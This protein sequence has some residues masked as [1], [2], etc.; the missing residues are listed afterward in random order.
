MNPGRGENPIPLKHDSVIVSISTCPDC[1]GRGWFLINPF[2]TGGH[3]GCGGI[4]NH[5]QCQTCADAERYW[6]EH[7][8]LPDGLVMPTG[9]AA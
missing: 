1:D 4:G 7:G 5:C 8:R 3:D 9:G 6:K 2:A